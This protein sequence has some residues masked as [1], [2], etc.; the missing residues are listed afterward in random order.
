M[1]FLYIDTDN[2]LI[3]T[4]QQLGES[5]FLALDTEFIRERTYFSQLCLI[6]I[7]DENTVACIDPLAISNLSPLRDLLFSKKIT[8]VMHATHQDMEIFFKLW[9]A[10]PEPVYDTQIAATLLGMGESIGYASLVKK[11]LAVDL[12]KSHTRTDWSQRPLS[13]KQLEYAADDVRYLAQLYPV[14][15]QKLQSLGRLEW[16]K[17]DFSALCLPDRYQTKP[18]DAWRKVKGIKKLKRKQLAVLQQLAAW[19]EQQAVK[20]DKPRRRVVSDE[21]LVDLSRLQPNRV[22][23]LSGFRSI[24][25]KTLRSN[26]E[27]L[28]GLVKSALALAPEKWPELPTRH[29]LTADEDALVDAL[30]ALLKLISADV[31]ITASSIAARKDLEN[32]VR[33][34]RELDVLKGWRYQHA[35]QQLLDFLDGNLS[36]H[37]RDGK[38]RM[39]VNADNSSDS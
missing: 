23:E 4:C 6:Q 26:G 36:L 27:S 20:R 3:E 14:Q 2:T 32:L 11:M 29:P 8:K 13:P 7:A 19:R 10:L 34:G 25:E 38:L 5:E 15:K 33:G 24:N 31:R 39:S 17:D 37:T 12:D 16:L 1:T 22:S 21:A 9:G 18:D 28:I 35:G 30:A